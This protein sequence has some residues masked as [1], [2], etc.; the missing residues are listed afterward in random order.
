MWEKF[1]FQKVWLSNFRQV[2]V[3]SIAVFLS[4]LSMV[5]PAFFHVWF[6]SPIAVHPQVTHMTQ[7][8]SLVVH[9]SHQKGKQ[10][11]HQNTRIRPLS[12]PYGGWEG[13]GILLSLTCFSTLAHEF[14]P[15]V[16]LLSAS[17]FPQH[18][19]RREDTHAH[20]CSFS[21]AGGK[22]CGYFHCCQEWNTKT[23]QYSN[24]R[25]ASWQQTLVMYP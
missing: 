24:L 8:L 18:D 16:S 2:P 7:L 15:C 13:L 9:R 22:A 21:V 10:Q 1:P 6:P 5:C 14:T 20:A 17:A 3:P 11:S 4:F 23:F 25:V 19:Y 12:F